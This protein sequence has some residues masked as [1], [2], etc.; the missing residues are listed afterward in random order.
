MNFTTWT[1]IIALTLFAAL[2]TP[3]LLAAQDQAK[4]K[5]PHKYHHYQIVDPGTF[6]G[7]SS[8]LYNGVDVASGFINNRGTLVGSADTLTVDPYCLNYPDCYAAHAFQLKNG[9]TTDLGVLPGSVSGSQVGWISP[10]GLMVGV[11]DNGQ[12]DPLTGGAL[13]QIHAVLW[14]HG[15][16]TDLGTLEGGYFSFAE[17]VNS[18]GEVVG[19]GQNTIP[20]PNSMLTGYGYQSRAFLWDKQSG[21]Q[22]LGTL[23]G[24]TDAGALFVNERGQVTGWSYNSS[25]PNLDNACFGNSLTTGSFIWDRKNGMKDIGN[26]GGTSCTLTHDLNNRGQVVGGSDVPGEFQHPFVWNAATG[27]TDLGT[28]DG[29]YGVANAINEHGDVVGLGSNGVLHAML[30]RK[31]GG[32]WKMTDLGT[33]NGGNCGF[34]LSINASG[35]VVG[36]SGPDNCSLPF[37]WEDGGPMVDLNTLV[38][39][40]S[41]LQLFESAQINDHGEID[42]QGVDANGNNHAVLL[43]P[44]DENHAGVEGCDY[45]MVDAASAARVG[46]KPAA[47]HPARLTPRGPM[48]GR[49]NRFRFSRDQR[50]PGFGTSATP[51]EKPALSANAVTS[52]LEADHRLGQEPFGR[53]SGYCGANSSGL[54]GYCIAYNYYSCLAKPSSACPKGQ[55]AKKPGY[56][57]CSS[58]SQRFVDLGRGCGF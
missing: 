13:P 6:G 27:I 20:D 53:H 14:E 56:F 4:P 12:P 30:W 37:L 5:H 8:H 52:F 17:A 7:P 21:M 46:P 25:N 16:M 41:G 26:L 28:P 43:I 11:S 54:T 22:D 18:R 57:R 33:L 32:K 38:P 34:A 55:K 42:V 3:V 51:E 45:S 50:T 19:W 23:P 2:V 39:P 35:Q 1:R 29:G 44:C 9:V 10:N 40:N 24:G 15:G 36:I 58:S 31:R 47:R 48:P 49:F